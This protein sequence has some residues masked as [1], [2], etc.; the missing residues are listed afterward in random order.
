MTAMFL[1]PEDVASSGAKDSIFIFTA[2]LIRLH[3]VLHIQIIQ[4]VTEDTTAEAASEREEQGVP[5]PAPVPVLVLVREE[6]EPDA[7]R[8]TR[9]EFPK[10]FKKI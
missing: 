7:H 6:A 1:L 8:R 5:V 9:T 3:S 2:V 10:I 4:T